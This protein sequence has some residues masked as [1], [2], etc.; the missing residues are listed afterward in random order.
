MLIGESSVTYSTM[1]W[2]IIQPKIKASWWI[3]K[4]FTR[5]ISS[6]KTDYDY[7]L[8]GVA[9]D[10]FSSLA[11]PRSTRRWRSCCVSHLFKFG[12]ACDM[13][14]S[15]RSVSVDYGN[16]HDFWKLWRHSIRFMKEDTERNINLRKVHLSAVASQGFS[17]VESA[18]ICSDCSRTVLALRQLHG[19]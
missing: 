7:S 19:V 10:F 2:L 3:T 1:R 17:C 11:Y 12:D 4:T 8:K 6:Q 9:R 16:I 5:Q 18:L 14:S 13:L 15:T